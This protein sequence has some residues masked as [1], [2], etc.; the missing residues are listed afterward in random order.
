MLLW[1]CIYSVILYK[2]TLGWSCFGDLNPVPLRHRGRRIYQ[3]CTIYLQGK[4]DVIR[5]LELKRA[6]RPGSLMDSRRS[7]LVLSD[8]VIEMLKGFEAPVGQDKGDPD[9]EGDDNKK[10]IKNKLLGTLGSEYSQSHN[11]KVNSPYLNE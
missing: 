8:E 1:P 2:F 7:T 11:H 10:G 6:K 4:C 5:C 3:L 9:P